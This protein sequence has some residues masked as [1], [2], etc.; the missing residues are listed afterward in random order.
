MRNVVCVADRGLLSNDN[1][2]ALQ[3]AGMYYIVG[4]QLKSLPRKVQAQVLELDAYERLSP[5]ACR[6]AHCR[7]VD[8]GW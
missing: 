8:G 3:E 5:A 7:R 4:A 6:C 1:L 2:Q